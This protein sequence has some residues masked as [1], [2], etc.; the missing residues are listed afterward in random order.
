[1]KAELTRLVVAP[2]AALA[3][4][5]AL[6]AAA[7]AQAQRSASMY[8]G[9]DQVEAGMPAAAST[10]LLKQIGFDQKLNAQVPLNLPFVDEEG[11][12]VKLGDYFGQRPVVLALVY[13]D[14]PML[15]TQVLNGAVAS[16]K[17]LSLEAGKDFD[18]VVVSFDPREG[19]KLALAKRAVYVK[20]YGSHG[21]AADGFHFLTGQEPSIK[22]L[23]QA[24][25]FRYVWDPTAKQFAHP[26]GIVVIT[27]TGRVARYLFG[28]DY[29]PRDLRFSLVEASHDKIGTPV[30]DLLL[31]CYHYNP[32]TG[33]YGLLTMRLLR[34]AGTLTLLAMG[35]FIFIMWRMERRGS[36]RTDPGQ[37]GDGSAASGRKA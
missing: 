17:A 29:S 20:D 31:Y 18:F 30:D 19:P 6:P 10:S 13:Y 36:H 26:T 16:L 21:D 5:V 27:P 28:I 24:V 14:C 23:T 11:R 33:K 15:C 35:S 37:P 7:R 8:A 32:E 1:M 12:T 34:I 4:L 22:A 25:G 3:L 9:G 2:L